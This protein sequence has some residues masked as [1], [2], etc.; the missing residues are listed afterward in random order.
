MD[1][2]NPNI[3]RHQMKHITE[4]LKVQ[5]CFSLKDSCCTCQH[6]THP[7]MHKHTPTHKKRR[8]AL[9]EDPEVFFC[10]TGIMKK[11]LCLISYCLC[12]RHCLMLALPRT[13]EDLMH[14]LQFVSRAYGYFRSKVMPLNYFQVFELSV[15][16]KHIYTTSM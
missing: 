7:H 3:Y 2:G 1:I 15:G 14:I 5:K 10:Q 6:N 13:S 8:N 9:W 4:N 16:I 12:N 11:Y